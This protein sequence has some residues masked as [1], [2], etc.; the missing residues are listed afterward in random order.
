MKGLI[1][2]SLGR[3]DEAFA[4]AKDALKQN[5]KSHVCWHVYGLILR[6]PSVRNYD[7]AIKAYKM[8]LRLEPESAQILRDLALLQVQMRD[9]KGYVDSRN[10]MLLARPQLRQNWSAMAIAHHLAGAVRRGR[11]GTEQVR[12]HDRRKD[13]KVGH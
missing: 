1:T 6:S 2:N 10:T 8:A 13:L 12:E 4:Y 9:Y 7:E 3:T 5:M 11:E